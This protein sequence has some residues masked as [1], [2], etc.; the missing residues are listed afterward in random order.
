MNSEQEV[1]D[2]LLN[3]FVDGELDVAEKSRLL[4][5]LAQNP[6]LRARVCELWQLKEMVRSGH[7]LKTTPKNATGS[8]RKLTR[9]RFT[10][11]LAACLILAVG[12]GTGWSVR[13]TRDPAR[14]AGFELGAK[15]LDE[16]KVILHLASADSDRLKTALDEAEELA[17]RRDKAGNPV[18]VELMTNAGGLDLLRTDVSPYS[19]R[20]KALRAAHANLHFLACQTA[21]DNLIRKG[22][23]V[24]LL[25]EAEITESA[26]DQIIKRL[27]QGWVYIQ[28]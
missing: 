16:G 28:A 27:K 6:G 1:S 21:I 9:Q 12:A 5:Q 7:P 3:A 17:A 25:P 19:E 26:V 10:Q 22:I 2:E 24:D 13:G 14:S 8:G 18:R 11:A 23:R 15:Y 4:E 20:I